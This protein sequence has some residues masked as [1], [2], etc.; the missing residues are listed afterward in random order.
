MPK[1]AGTFSEVPTLALEIY[2]WENCHPMRGRGSLSLSGVLRGQRAIVRMRFA[3]KT[4]DDVLWKVFPK[5]IASKNR[6]INTR[7]ATREIIGAVIELKQPRAR[8]SRTETRGKPFSC[9]GE[10]L[11]YLSKDN[12]LD[13]IYHYIQRYK[14]ESE[15]KKT[16]F[17]GY[18]KRLFHQ[19]RINQIDSVISLL[20]KNRNSRRAVIQLFN[21]E[22]IAQRA[23]EAPCTC[24]MQL[25]VRKRKLDLIVSMRSND[26]YKGLPHDIFCFTMLQEVMARTLGVD[27]GIY[28][29]FAGSLH[30]YEYDIDNA[31]QYLSEG[32]QPTIQ[33][34]PMPPGS[35][36]PALDVVLEAEEAIRKKRPVHPHTWKLPSYWA[37]L[38]R[39]LQ[40]LDATGD[41]STLDEIKAKMAFK[42]YTIY[43]EP[44]KSM[45]PRAVP[46]L[47][48]PPQFEFIF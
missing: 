12:K 17:G 36:W 39:L 33:M 48:P 21:A 18:G 10:F 37:D 5:L 22:D 35:P 1:V 14:D 20:K 25:L 26:A 11:W 2:P 40:A 32:L 31:K 9:L 45:K 34:P 19:R 16:V 47:A 41:P 38:V 6:V 4:L 13:F 44:R 8:L 29:H 28:R 7:G 27:V 3:G 15:D 30:L 46:P 23:V 42:E 43:I 24:T